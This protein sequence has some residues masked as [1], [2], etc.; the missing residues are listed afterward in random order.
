[1]LTGG[2][3]ERVTC[4]YVAMSLKLH[5]EFG[6]RREEAMK[7]RPEWA[8]QGGHLKLKGSWCKGKRERVLP[9]RTESQRAVLNEA[10]ALAGTT[11]KGSLIPTGKYVQQVKRFEYQC[12]KVG[13]NGLHGL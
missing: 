13:L 4:P 12:R 11:E 5:R 1:M 10:K 8:G 6:L 7:T 3:M 2:H 9:I